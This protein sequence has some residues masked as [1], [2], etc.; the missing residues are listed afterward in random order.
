MKH[1]INRTLEIIIII[2]RVG[3]VTKSNTWRI[4]VAGR[5]IFNVMT[6]PTITVQIRVRELDVA[7]SIVCLLDLT[8]C[9][10]VEITLY[11][12]YMSR[13]TMQRVF[14]FIPTRPQILVCGSDRCFDPS[15]FLYSG[16]LSQRREILAETTSS[17]DKTI[18]NS[19]TM[20][21]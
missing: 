4:L 2:R 3:Q 14:W 20:R 11:V 21:I 1:T 9:G 16:D 18:N 7:I 10:Q 6:I 17:V 13:W 5:P 8:V 19:M 15:D 12:V